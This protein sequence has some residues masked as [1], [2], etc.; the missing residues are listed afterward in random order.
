MAKP[1]TPVDVI[2]S[3]SRTKAAAKKCNTSSDC[4]NALDKKVSELVAAAEA[5]A[6]A[7]KRETFGPQDL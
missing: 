3:E 2:I 4:Y 5:G 1:A 6:I 7:N